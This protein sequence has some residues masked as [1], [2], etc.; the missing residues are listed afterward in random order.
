MLSSA[1]RCGLLVLV[2][3]A[4]ILG[5][6]GCSTA[7]VA[8]P[9]PTVTVT[10][11]ATPGATADATDPGA[12]DPGNSA[13]APAVA[14]TDLP[15]VTVGELPTEAVAMLA[16]IAEGGPYAY[17]QDGQTFQNREGILPPAPNG[18][19]AEYTVETPGSRDRGA[20]RLVVADSGAIFYTDDH[21]Q[22]FREVIA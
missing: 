17:S 8:P 5:L 20:R 10:V 21:Y 3:L 2:A 6:A 7:T 18:S 22:S 12:P 9:A 19:Y 11:T 13:V 4:V 16:L 15:T 14:S 1:R